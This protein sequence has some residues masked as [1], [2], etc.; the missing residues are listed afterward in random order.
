MKST[1]LLLKVALVFV[2]SAGSAFAQQ[3]PNAPRTIE[4][5]Y[6]GNIGVL[7]PWGRGFVRKGGFNLGGAC[8]QVAVR[9]TDAA[10]L[11]GEMCGTHQF[12]PR[13]SQDD[14]GRRRGLWPLSEPASQQVDSLLSIRGGVRLS[15]RARKSLGE[16]N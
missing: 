14:D 11:V 10:A 15:H 13:S 7:F 5:S 9:A 12:L 1:I 4:I 2:L 3:P 16:G 6:T 8:I